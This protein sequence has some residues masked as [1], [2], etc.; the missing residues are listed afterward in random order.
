MKR[1][2]KLLSMTIID[3]PANNSNIFFVGGCSPQARPAAIRQ[4]IPACKKP[5]SYCTQVSF[6]LGSPT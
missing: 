6:M 3:K 2:R 5:F 1:K 4:C